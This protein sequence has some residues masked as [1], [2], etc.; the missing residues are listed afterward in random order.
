M[1]IFEHSANNIGKALI[2]HYQLVAHAENAGA[3]RFRQS[4]PSRPER[5]GVIQAH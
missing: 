1:V 4:T 2:G 3:D 5:H